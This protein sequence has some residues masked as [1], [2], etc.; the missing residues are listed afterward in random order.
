M[1]QVWL[2]PPSLLE[3]TLILLQFP[4]PA[5]VMGSEDTGT[6]M[7]QGQCDTARSSAGI[8]AAALNPMRETCMMRKELY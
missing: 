7:D 8:E 2:T 6:G 3:L 4:L 5:T 1:A